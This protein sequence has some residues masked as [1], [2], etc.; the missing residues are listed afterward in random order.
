MSIIPRLHTSSIL[1]VRTRFLQ[2]DLKLAALPAN[3]VVA[4]QRLD[5]ATQGW[6]LGLKNSGGREFRYSIPSEVHVTETELARKK[7]Q[8]NADLA[9]GS[10]DQVP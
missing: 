3:H 9:A 5:P 1:N 6:W 4:I 8:I 7:Y 2:R 10:S